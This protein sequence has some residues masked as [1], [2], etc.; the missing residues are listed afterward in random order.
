MEYA[1]TKKRGGVNFSI[2]PGCFERNVRGGVTVQKYVY[3]I[4]AFFP[5]D[6]RFMISKMEE[7]LCSKNLKNYSRSIKY[8]TFFFFFW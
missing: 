5:I 2:F 1:N 3:C 7:N 4:N 6:L 8:N